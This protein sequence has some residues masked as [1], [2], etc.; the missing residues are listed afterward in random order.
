MDERTQN[1]INKFARVINFNNNELSLLQ[2]ALTHR[3]V[4]EPNN[5]RLEFL[6]D[7]VLNFIIAAELYTMLPTADEGTLTCLRAKLVRKEALTT[8]AEQLNL[9]DY[10]ILGQG[11]RKSGGH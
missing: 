2:M 9:G 6:G 1:K 5:E 3:S 11:E 10:L 7:A 4:G 8:L